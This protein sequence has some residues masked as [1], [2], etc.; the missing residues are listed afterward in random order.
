VWHPISCLPR[1]YYALLVTTSRVHAIDL[2]VKLAPLGPYR[3]VLRGWPRSGVFNVMGT[4]M[5]WDT[6]RHRA[7]SRKASL[8]TILC[9]PRTTFLEQLSQRYVQTTNFMLFI[10]ITFNKARCYLL[11]AFPICP[12]LI[13]AR[14]AQTI[15]SYLRRAP[16]SRIARAQ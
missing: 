9:I 15:A 14:D 6:S 11:G 12:R 1:L 2:E 10:L 7:K 5:S 3:Y 4:L 16:F 8:M 13:P